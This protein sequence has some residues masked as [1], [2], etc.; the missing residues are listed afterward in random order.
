MAPPRPST[1]KS[2]AHLNTGAS[3]SKLVK[4]LN[5]LLEFA[6]NIKDEFEMDPIFNEIIE[7]SL[8]INKG[9]KSVKL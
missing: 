9:M 3:R 4:E 7:P 2:Q 1:S 8:R 5:E 6:K